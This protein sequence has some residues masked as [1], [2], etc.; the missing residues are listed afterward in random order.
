VVA[1]GGSSLIMFPPL[2]QQSRRAAHE[3]RNVRRPYRHVLPLVLA[4]LPSAG[5]GLFALLAYLHYPTAYDPIHHT[6]S[7]LGSP[8]LN[9]AGSG[10]YRVGCVIGGTT[11]IAFFLTLVLWR[12]SGTALQNRFLLGVQ[13]LG[14]IAG[15]AMVLFAVYADNVSGAH[16]VVL[17]IL[18][19]S[20]LGFLLLSLIALY[21]PN[22]PQAIRVTVTL[23]ASTAILVMYL[24]PNHHW[25]E[26]VPTFLAQ[27]YIWVVGYETAKT[28]L[29]RFSET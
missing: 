12:R 26:W 20:T 28:R 9:P 5:F 11:T 2:L 23:L 15:T 3:G 1:V 14:M 19:N 6:L 18:A 8:L 22:R 21:R 24:I 17:G 16:L 13:A 10:F 25:A 7:E 29:E 27:A 4:L